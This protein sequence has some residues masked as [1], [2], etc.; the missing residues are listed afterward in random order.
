MKRP[1]IIALG[2]ATHLHLEAERRSAFGLAVF[3][4]ANHNKCSPVST[5]N[6]RAIADSGVNRKGILVAPAAAKQ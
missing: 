2:I 6:K 5:R 4:A 1:L 3:T